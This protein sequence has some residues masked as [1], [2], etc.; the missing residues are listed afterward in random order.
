MHAILLP[1]SLFLSTHDFTSSSVATYIH[2][3]KH[4]HNSLFI[5]LHYF[6]IP[7]FSFPL[8]L[9][10]CFHDQFCFEVKSDFPHL[11][12]AEIDFRLVFWFWFVF[13][14]LFFN[15]QDIAWCALFFCQLQSLWFA[16]T[17][18]IK[19]GPVTRIANIC[20]FYC[21]KG[22]REDEMFLNAREGNKAN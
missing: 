16:R 8:F 3:Y 18:G 7:S 6:F 1:L 13:I 11:V 15:K 20:L 14:Y 17:A 12:L 19:L 4:K 10:L 21:S 9:F 2:T 5:L 22:M